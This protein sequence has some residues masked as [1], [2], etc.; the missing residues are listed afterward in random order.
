MKIEN[1]L[2]TP[3]VSVIIP[4]YNRA[5]YLRIAIDSVLAQTYKNF[6]LLILD[7]HSSDHTQEIIFSY[8]DARIKSVRHLANIGGIA[9]WIYG[10]HLAKGEFF[11]VLGDDDFY[12][13]DFLE[14]RVKAF[15]DFPDVVSVFSD[16]EVSDEAGCISGLSSAQNEKNTRRLS[17]KA[18]LDI[19]HD[20]GWQVG[21]NLFKRNIVVEIWDECIRA[22]K[23][24]DTAVHVQIALFYSAVWIPQKGLV[25]RQHTQQDSHIG[26]RGI[27]IGY[28][29]AFAEPLIFNNP[30]KYSK[31]L[32]LGAWWAIDIMARNSLS[33]F[34]TSIARKLFLCAG[35]LRPMHARTWCRLFLALL[36]RCFLEKIVNLM[37]TRERT[38]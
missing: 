20:G 33:K 29:N 36:P 22:G 37:R 38:S 13:C 17:E 31:E 32:K 15:A 23:A 8:S 2:A 25:Y 6:E 27:L 16:H 10:M 26:G 18:L 14:A 30:S 34:D 19:L 28:V 12:R 4:T 24:F 5:D 21:S 1:T 9:N 35:I 3:F 7:N 11:S